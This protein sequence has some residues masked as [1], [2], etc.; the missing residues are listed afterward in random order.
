MKVSSNFQMYGLAIGIIFVAIL[1]A[2]WPK[3][4]KELNAG[5][6][7]TARDLTVS[8]EDPNA[9]YT[10]QDL[11]T[12][13]AKYLSRRVNIVLPK[14]K[15]GDRLVIHNGY[16]K[17]SYS[18]FLG[19]SS[20]FNKHQIATFVPNA[21]EDVIC[22]NTNGKWDCNGTVNN[23]AYGNTPATVNAS[24]DDYLKLLKILCTMG[25]KDAKLDPIV[26]CGFDLLSLVFSM[27][28]FAKTTAPLPNL[29][30]IA[31]VVAQVVK[32]QSDQ[33]YITAVNGDYKNAATL[34]YDYG[35]T[36]KFTQYHVNRE[37]AQAG[38]PSIVNLA[39]RTALYNY[40]SPNSPTSFITVL[41]NRIVDLC[42]NF[43]VHDPASG[44]GGYGTPD[45][46]IPGAY[47]WVHGNNWLL[48]MLM[49]ALYMALIQ[50][51][52]FVDINNKDINGNWY[53]PWSSSLMDYLQAAG[54]PFVKGVMTLW[55]MYEDYGIRYMANINANQNISQGGYYA[56]VLADY[57]QIT[58][59]GLPVPDTFGNTFLPVGT[60]V[61]VTEIQR[62]GRYEDYF[63]SA[64]GGIGVNVSFPYTI[65]ATDTSANQGYKGCTQTYNDNQIINPNRAQ[66]ISQRAQDFQT[67]NQ[68][69]VQTINTFLS[70]A[71]LTISQPATPGGKMIFV[72]A[73]QPAAPAWWPNPSRPVPRGTPF[74]GFPS[75][76]SVYG[77]TLDSRWN[78]LCVS[79]CT[80]G[81]A[82][83]AG[84]TCLPDNSGPLDVTK[85]VTA[86][87]CRPSD[88]NYLGFTYYLP[89]SAEQIS[90]FSDAS[91]Y[92]VVSEGSWGIPVTPGNPFPPPTA[93]NTLFTCITNDSYLESSGEPTESNGLIGS[94]SGTLAK[95]R[96]IMAGF[97]SAPTSTDFSTTLYTQNSGSNPFTILYANANMLAT[98][99]APHNYDSFVA[100]VTSKSTSAGITTY[101]FSS[102]KISFWKYGN[103]KITVDSDEYS[104]GEGST[105]FTFSSNEWKNGS[106]TAKNASAS[107]YDINQN[108]DVLVP[109]VY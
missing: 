49:L 13:N 66:F 11:P 77:W 35:Y 28:G 42:D 101:T 60:T 73:Y 20:L 30:Q 8:L 59:D 46:N 104:P 53:N 2:L 43:V 39:T 64:K 44:S 68:D 45:P 109:R 88:T 90:W 40:L 108:V 93:V 74:L 98:E 87:P 56:N 106:F 65:D 82:P 5:S 71:G 27:F 31:N 29:Q 75:A 23:M 25:S 6:W 102:P 21:Q 58:S 36:Q 61:N 37:V 19:P 85:S 7:S 62:V 50:E 15:T 89:P 14:G 63:C 80:A 95:S 51:A 76:N 107:L 10:L 91:T 84:N 94:N 70:V 67:Y 1:V 26:A 83:G 17:Q 100:T 33:D 86:N 96:R 9:N 38:D 55:A 16:N 12:I 79:Q 103:H 41:G 105:S 32:A 22:D 57:N 24:D 72:N 81:N 48:L 54:N 52:M 97:T 69:I 34:L 99:C 92:P 18:A 3:K 4:R 47:V 78:L